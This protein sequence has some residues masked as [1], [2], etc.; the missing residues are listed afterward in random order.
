[1]GGE[2]IGGFERVVGV[3][4]FSASRPRPLLKPSSGTA[5]SA[6]PLELVEEDLFWNINRGNTDIFHGASD[7]LGAW[8]LGRGQYAC[9]DG[10]VFALEATDTLGGKKYGPTADAWWMVAPSGTEKQPGV[11][12][13]Y[14]AWNKF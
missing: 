3:R 7:R 5:Q 14:G 10:C 11:N 8:H 4:L 6:S 12:H 9:P 2:N 1:M 13:G